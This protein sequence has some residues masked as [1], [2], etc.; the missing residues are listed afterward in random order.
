[1]LSVCLEEMETRW[2][3]HVTSLPGCFASADTRD[4]AVSLLPGAIQEYLA[5]RRELGDRNDLPS[6]SA[7]LRV[8]EVVKEWAYPPDPD[9]V[10]NAFFACDALPL[11]QE[12]LPAIHLVQ[13][14]AYAGLLAAAAGLAPEV[15]HTPVE[16]EWSI[17]GILS[18]CSRAAW[19]YLDQLDMAPRQV[20]EP[21]GWEE[22]LALVQE[23]LLASLPSLAGMKRIETR[24]GELWSPRKMVRRSLWHL[25]DHTSHIYQFR[26]RLGV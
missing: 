3:A 20:V 7:E 21:R 19:W 18:H 10:V 24:S 23:T 14:G 16:G 12:E 1:M 15:L 4:Q 9:Y 2:V 25:R 11:Q 17:D 8:D 6:S 5:W 26:N 22:R 13:E